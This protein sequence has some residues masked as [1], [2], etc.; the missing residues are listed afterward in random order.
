MGLQ[1]SNKAVETFPSVRGIERLNRVLISRC[2]YPS[3]LRPTV[4]IEQQKAI[5]LYVAFFPS[6]FALLLSKRA[7]TEQQECSQERA[8]QA[9]GDLKTL[10]FY[11]DS[12][13]LFLCWMTLLFIQRICIGENNFMCAYVGH[14]PSFAFAVLVDEVEERT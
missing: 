3:R 8:R 7:T 9:D 11:W 13:L 2:E 10:W 6:R 5:I 1:N 4:S 14:D 12:G